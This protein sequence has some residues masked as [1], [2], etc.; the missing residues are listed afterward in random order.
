MNNYKFLGVANGWKE[1][2]EEL[3]IAKENNWQIIREDTRWGCYS[4]YVCH[5]GKFYYEVD[6]SG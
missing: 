3:K 1:F 6:S 4:R 5:E 2:P